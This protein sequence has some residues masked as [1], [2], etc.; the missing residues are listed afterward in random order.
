MNTIQLIAIAAVV[1][2]LAG[3]GA[4]HHWKT[5]SDNA[6]IVTQVVKVAKTDAKNE[7]QVEKQDD[8]DKI[9]IA[10]LQQDLAVARASS[11]ARGV[12]KHLTTKCVP[13]AEAG[14]RAGQEASSTREPAEG[15]GEAYRRFRDELL[16]AGATAEELRLQV[17]A[18]QAQWPR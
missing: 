14:T 1:A 3:F 12:P 10:Q 15:D 2:F 7:A 9:K 4:G 17:L 6:A 11:L 5:T 18:C 16:V 8:S 13:Q